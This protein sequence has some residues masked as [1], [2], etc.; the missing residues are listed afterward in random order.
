ME[1][2]TPK[3]RKEVLNGLFEALTETFLLFDLYSFKCRGSMCEMID[4]KRKLE[5]DENLLFSFVSTIIGRKNHRMVYEDVLSQRVII[6]MRSILL[7]RFD[8][9]QVVKRMRDH[10]IVNKFEEMKQLVKK[11][12]MDCLDNA[13]WTRDVDSN[14]FVGLDNQLYRWTNDGLIYNSKRDNEYLEKIKKYM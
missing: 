12:L 1:R 7:S 3:I 13:I 8:F 14:P 2:T 11:Q 4:L 5:E 6:V 10:T 9:L